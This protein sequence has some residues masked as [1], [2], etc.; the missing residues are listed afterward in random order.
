MH[1]D[2]RVEPM[3][4]TRM[5]QPFNH[6]EWVYK[7]KHDGFRALAYVND[8]KCGLVSRKSHVYKRFE[9][10]NAEIASALRV[11][12]AVLDGEIVC[13]D[14]DGKSQFYSLM[15]RRG[16]A[17]FCAFDLIEPNGKDLRSLSLLQRKQ[18]LKRLMSIRSD[19]T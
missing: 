6:S 17:R 7:I 14:K 13:L 8:G 4:L 2:H 12:S 11:R 10:L 3:T 1:V 9:T 19:S 5:R 18:L 16:P 15:F